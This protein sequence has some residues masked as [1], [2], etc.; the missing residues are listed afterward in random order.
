MIA[1]IEGKLV[2]KHPTHAV[3]DCAGVGYH[4]NISLNTYSNMGDKEHCRLLTH[5]VVREDAHI[6]F[7]FADSDERDLFRHLISV[8]GVGPSTAL[9]VL[10]SLSPQ[11][12]YQ[13]IMNDD[14]DLLKT[15]KGIGGKSAQRII[16]DLKDK[17]H[18]QDAVL[19][20]VAGAGTN[21]RQEALSALSALG[22]SRNKAGKSVDKV[23]QN[24]GAE[25]SV[26][27]LIKQALKHL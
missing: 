8:S 25:M 27:E 2:E 22:F 11:E 3:I 17:L 6:L 26:E 15:V 18:K 23:M 21:L 13:A 9:L 7:G 14:V 20:L 5:L 24:G 1:H 12:V 4:L 19:D 10:S 16:L